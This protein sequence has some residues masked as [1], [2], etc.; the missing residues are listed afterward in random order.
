MQKLFFAILCLTFAYGQPANAEIYKSTEDYV[1]Q[2]FVASPV[3]EKIWITG[4]VKTQVEKILG[5]KFKQLRAEYW[6]GE[7][8]DSNKTVWI[9]DEIGKY[10]PIT[11][12]FTVTGGKIEDVQVLVYRE[13]H[14][15]EVKYP[16]F[17]KQ[18]KQIAL[19][20]DYGLDKHI[21]GISGATLSVNS[22]KKMARLA[23]YLHAKV[24]QDEKT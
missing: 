5:R 4:E 8:K 13:S 2:A 15:W 14:G 19:T 11:T 12:G 3:P 22:L 18:F 24:A 16:F 23:L 10:K 7:G 9:L 20:D 17:T 1:N 6:R 21:D